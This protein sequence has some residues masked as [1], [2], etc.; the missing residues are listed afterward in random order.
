MDVWLLVVQF[1]CAVQ[2]PSFV[3]LPFLLIVFG[4]QPILSLT[5]SIW[6]QRN[7][8][9]N[10]NYLSLS[11]KTIKSIT[12][13][14][15]NDDFRYNSIMRFFWNNRWTV[16]IVWMVQSTWMGLGRRKN[17]QIYKNH[18]LWFSG[19]LLFCGDYIPGHFNGMFLCIHIS[20]HS[21]SGKCY[22][23]RHTSNRFLALTL[24]YIPD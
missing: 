17:V 2:F 20:I 10:Y 9:V 12:S 16:S 4:Q 21:N 14:F 15:L 11:S 23:Y 5:T 6:M 8:V 13:K 22:F 24:V 19:I 1:L 7:R 3:Y 18:G